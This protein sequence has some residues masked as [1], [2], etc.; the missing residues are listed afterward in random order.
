MTQKDLVATAIE[1][2]E[3]EKQEAEIQK[4][5]DIIRVYLEKIL[6]KK[7]VI[8]KSQ[9][10][11]KE[12]E[13][14]L[15]DLKQ[16]RLDKIEER[17]KEDPEHNKVSLIVIKRI[18]KEYIP[19]FPWRSPY[20][21]EWNDFTSTYYPYQPI[22]C[23]TTCDCETNVNALNILTASGTMFQNFS[24]GTYNIEGRIINL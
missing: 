1:Q 17:Q 7:E 3:K 16:G 22:N 10:E 13:A 19:M 4:I 20:V 12:L 24:G 21:I 23:Q 18:E 5:K 2:V 14:D 6:N 9:A 8:K 11:L 15:D